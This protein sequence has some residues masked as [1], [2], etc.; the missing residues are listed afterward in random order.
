METKKTIFYN[1]IV[2]ELWNIR[3][4]KDNRKRVNALIV[5]YFDLNN[6]E[7]RKK[8]EFPTDKSYKEMMDSIPK[9]II[10]N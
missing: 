1:G 9:E 5:N 3:A 6:F 8:F 4:F 7:Y 10:I 2:T